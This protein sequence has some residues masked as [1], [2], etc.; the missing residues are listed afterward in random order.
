MPRVRFF[1]GHY[2]N[3][4]FRFSRDFLIFFRSRNGL[5]ILGRREKDLE[6]FSWFVFFLLFIIE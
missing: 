4:I 5:T 1:G 6:G 3:L 2:K